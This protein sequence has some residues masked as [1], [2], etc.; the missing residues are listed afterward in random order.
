MLLAQHQQL[1]D[2]SAISTEVASA[3]GYF[4]ATKKVELTEL[5]FSRGQA[6]VPALVIPIWNVFGEKAMHLARPDEP[7]INGGRALKYEMPSGS[8]MVLDVP[9]AAR[10]ALDDP[11]PPLFITEGAR[12]ADAAVSAGLCCVSLIGTWAWRGTN[13]NG[14]KTLLPDF[15]AIAFNDRE[16]YVVFDSD[17]MTKESVHAALQRFVPALRQR[18]AD[19]RVIYLPPGSDGS[20]VGLDD[21]LAASGTV[22]GLL[23]HAQRE[24]RALPVKRDTS[25]Y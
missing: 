22:A 17:V 14:G 20:K 18:G 10:P 5:G 25:E 13:E 11:S 2:E 4:S 15:E 21:F 3:R 23:A 7:R 24:L 1:L 12:K 9:P 8:R 16:T 19:V 6:R